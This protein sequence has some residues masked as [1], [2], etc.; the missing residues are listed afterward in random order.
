MLYHTKLSL[1][2]RFVL[3]ICLETPLESQFVNILEISR[4]L[5]SGI[6]LR[7]THHK[8]DTL[9]KA[10]KDFVPILRFSGQTISKLISI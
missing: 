2:G 8:A 5:Y 7:R 3:V 1:H 6:S 9:Y 4:L 10:D